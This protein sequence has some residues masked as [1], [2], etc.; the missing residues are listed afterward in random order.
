MYLKFL[1]SFHLKN[2]ALV[3]MIID[4]LGSV[5]FDDIA[6]FRI[7]G[8]IA[9][10][11]YAFLLVNGIK[12]TSDISK[13]LK[14]LF[15]W[16]IISEI[17]YDL[18]FNDSFFSLK[19]QNIFFT[20]FLG[21]LGIH[22]YKIHESILYRILVFTFGILLGYVLKVDYSWYGV[23]LIYGMYLVR[24]F[25][26]LKFGFIQGIS[27]FYAVCAINLTQF[28]AFIGILPIYLYNGKQG[29]KTGNI[30][31]SYYAIHL[32]IFYIIKTFY[33]FK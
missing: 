15:I 32:L 1:N 17:P 16:G 12:Y 5:F 11:L 4:H 2:I 28:F 18:V 20:L 10:V 9:F 26:L 31:Y 19:S 3:T 13:Y 22:L 30:Y 14:K 33:F 21:A 24:K 8:R 6:I 29:K 27:T 25:E 23:S 7:I